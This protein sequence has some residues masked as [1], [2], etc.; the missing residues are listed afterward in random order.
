MPTLAR[1]QKITF[2]EMRR[3]GVRGVLVYCQNYQCS[4]SV[5]I[6]ADA[7]PDDVHLSDLEPRFVCKKGADVRPNFNGNARGPIG[8]MGYRIIANAR[9]PVATGRRYS[10]VYIPWLWSTFWQLLLSFMRFCCKHC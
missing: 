10:L 3:S 4:H 6:S 5:A 7:W 8:G 9:S 1:P 2:A